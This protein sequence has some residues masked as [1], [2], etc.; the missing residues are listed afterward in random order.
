MKSGR[1]LWDELCLRYQQGVDE[2]RALRRDWDSLKGRIDEERFT[3]VA[4]RLARQEKEAINWRDSCLLYFQQF[5]KR[6]LPTGVEPATHPLEHYKQIL[7]N[8]PG[9]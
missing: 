2:V 3:H 5:S 6:P 1:T 8:M 7:R 9:F 4:Q